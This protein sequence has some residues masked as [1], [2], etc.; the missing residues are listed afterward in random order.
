MRDAVERCERLGVLQTKTYAQVNLGYVLSYRGAHQDAEKVLLDAAE[1]CRKA[2]N[3]RLQGWAL[4]HLAHDFRVR[5]EHDRSIEV[6][7]RA[8]A[9]LSVS[10]GLRAWS[11]ALLADALLAAGRAEE[12]LPHATRAME[13]LV[14][15]GSMLQG[16]SFPPLILAEARHA[17]GDHVGARAAILDA[18]NRLQ[19]RAQA[20]PDERWR[21]T[22]LQ[23]PENARTI[24]LATAW[25]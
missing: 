11:R 14:R 13:D 15:L 22:F 21:A 18:R 24:E 25:A 9:L 6:A 1:S 10:P 5:G 7:T 2:S 16:E 8:E 23:I 12:A 19:L 4:S 20:L 17:L 3:P